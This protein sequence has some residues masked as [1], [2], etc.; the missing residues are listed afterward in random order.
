M[1]NVLFES[2]KFVPGVIIGL[3]N[4]K[5]IPLVNTVFV[6]DITWFICIRYHFVPNDISVC[7]IFRFVA[8]SF[9]MFVPDHILAP[10]GFCLF[11]IFL[12]DILFAFPFVPAIYFHFLPDII[13]SL[14]AIYFVCL[15]PDFNTFDQ[16]FSIYAIFA[17]YPLTARYPISARHPNSCSISLS[18]R[19][20]CRLVIRTRYTICFIH[21]LSIFIFSY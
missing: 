13:C 1:R 17:R 20:I 15:F 11:Y 14:A 2:M 10:K 8:E 4:V 3:S 6:P 5:N 16:H 9:C 18:I 12:P 21:I 7:S 19:V